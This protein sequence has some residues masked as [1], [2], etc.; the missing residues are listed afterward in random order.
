M[1][2]LYG[3]L[4]GQP[5]I[6]AP[7]TLFYLICMFVLQNWCMTMF[8]LYGRLYGQPSI[9]APHTLFYLYHWLWLSSIEI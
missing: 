2:S 3:R 5:S 1:F 9:P 7:H 8:S 4:Y 6:P